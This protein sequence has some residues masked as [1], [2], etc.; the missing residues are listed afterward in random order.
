M[1]QDAPPPIPFSLILLQAEARVAA[2][3][4]SLQQANRALDVTKADVRVLRGEL[5]DAQFREREAAEATEAER[6]VA[7][8]NVAKLECVIERADREHALFRERTE[9]RLEQLRI[10]VEETRE[11]ASQ[12]CLRA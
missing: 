3:E 4:M 6:R 5:E 7:T 8:E 10:A 11:N 1:V 9:G 12:V 2:A